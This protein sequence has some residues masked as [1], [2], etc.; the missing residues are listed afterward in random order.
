MHKPII[1]EKRGIVVDIT[2]ENEHL[3]EEFPTEIVNGDDDAKSNKLC[4]TREV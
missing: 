3:H 1:S 4:S 2:K